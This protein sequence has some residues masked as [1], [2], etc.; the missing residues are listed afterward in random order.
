MEQQTLLKLV[1]KPKDKKSNGNEPTDAEKQ[2]LQKEELQQL[3][4]AK[5]R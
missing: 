3:M 1:E 4:L 5:M 2:K